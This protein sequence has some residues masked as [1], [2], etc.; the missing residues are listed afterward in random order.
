MPKLLEHLLY[1]SH[2]APPFAI[3]TM[4]TTLTFYV[5]VNPW[6][7]PVLVFNSQIKYLKR[8]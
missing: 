1:R 6:F 7:E 4:C 3:S 2:N 5:R 8:K